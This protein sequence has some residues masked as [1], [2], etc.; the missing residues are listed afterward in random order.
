MRRLGSNV[1]TKASVVYVRASRVNRCSAYLESRI[2]DDAV[3]G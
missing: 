1:D 3:V 2:G